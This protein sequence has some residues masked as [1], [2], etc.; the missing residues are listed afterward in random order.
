[1]GRGA[2]RRA[3]G[4]GIPESVRGTDNTKMS[5]YYLFCSTCVRVCT[6][7]RAKDREGL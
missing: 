7:A 1:M 2:Q 5:Q 3:G 6:S 4:N